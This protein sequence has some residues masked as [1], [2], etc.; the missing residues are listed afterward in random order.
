M[1]NV[2]VEARPKG[3]PEGSAIDDY[4]VEDH[5]DRVLGVFRT[6]KEA[7]DWAKKQG[8]HPLVARVRHLNDKKKPDHWRSAE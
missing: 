5:N 4:V 8:H 6:Q 3:R 1:A 7:I 2:Y